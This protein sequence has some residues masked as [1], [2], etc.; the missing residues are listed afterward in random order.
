MALVRIPSPADG[1]VYLKLWE[2]A[3]SALKIPV[4][5]RQE[6]MDN[7]VTI[8]PSDTVFQNGINFR[9]ETDLLADYYKLNPNFGSFG[10]FVTIPLRLR[11]ENGSWWT[12]WG[13]VAFEAQAAGAAPRMY[14]GANHLVQVKCG[15]FRKDVTA[16]PSYATNKEKL[17]HIE[18]V[19]LKTEQEIH[20]E[21]S[22]VDL[23]GFDRMHDTFNGLIN[24]SS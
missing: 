17:E 21:L 14:N 6:I 8:D 7:F 9:N 16:Y 22:E 18:K 3:D 2:A 20:D 5:E 15:K 4:G 10:G 1:E 11:A 19:T 12:N 24:W 23:L 13:L